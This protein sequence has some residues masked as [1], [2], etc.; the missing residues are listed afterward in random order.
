MFKVTLERRECYEAPLCETVE[1][2]GNEM[3]CTSVEG[4]GYDD[5]PFNG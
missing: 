3:L 2:V 4:W 5:D 1:T